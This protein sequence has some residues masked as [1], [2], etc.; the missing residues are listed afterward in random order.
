MQIN[1]IEYLESRYSKYES[2]TAIKEGNKQICF[3]DLRRKSILLSQH[4]QEI[5]K[6][7]N[8]PIAVYL[9]KSIE[10]ILC[11]T[12]IL[13]SGNFYVPLDVKTPTE[14]M[15]SILESLNP[16]LI[17]TSS[18]L[19]KHLIEAGYQP[20]LIFE[21]DK[22]VMDKEFAVKDCFVPVNHIDT[23]P[24]YTLFT[25][26][27]TGKP[28]GVVVP[29]KAVIDF[30]DWAKERFNI[31]DTYIIGNQ[32]PLFFDHSVFDIYLMMST[33]ATLVL[34]PEPLYMFPSRLLD[35]LNEEKINLIF[36]VSSVLVN[37]ANYKLFEHKKLPFLKKV[38]FGG[39]VMP[40]R[41]LNY[42]RKNLKDVTYINM[43][44]PTETTVDSVHYIVDRDIPDEESVPI[45]YPCKNTNVLILN[46]EDKHAKT[47]ETG[48]LC[49]RGSSL[50]L[51]YYNNPEKTAEVFVQ[52]PLNK[53][54]PERIYRTGDI[55]YLNELGEIIYVCRN[56]FQIKHM[57]FR[58][59]LGDIEASVMSLEE[60]DSACVLYNNEKKEISLFYTSTRDIDESGLRIQLINKLPKY[61]IPTLYVQLDEMP[62]TPNGK[63]NRNA[64][65][66]LIEN[67]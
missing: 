54:Y 56:D 5:Y 4:I 38:F 44:G 28:K 23:N 11:F 42:W 9:P 12:A 57:G 61:M 31:D 53:H 27:S 48:E 66:H 14:R 8:S 43:Y 21:V 64:I 29:H 52:N 35:Y 46:E 26:G 65:R 37:V 13:Y 41:Q 51:G 60:V 24:A 63:I 59:E 55:V 30:I 10:S 22:V 25:S 50:A 1:I 15:E 62:L 33:G 58:I 45:G 39:E 18:T 3:G 19:K 40:T 7:T 20:E 49:I 16:K 34:I 6:S 17:L 2:K 36:W 67:D 32:S 47:G